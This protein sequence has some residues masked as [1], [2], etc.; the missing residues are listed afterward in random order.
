MAQKA[1]KRYRYR[2]NT[3]DLDW[4]E[5][6]ADASQNIGEVQR[7]ISAIAGAGLLIE[8]LRR[9]S[10]AG[11]VMAV[12]GL[13][14]LY[15]AATGY[16]LALGAMGIDMRP[17]QD[18]NRLGRRKVHSER[19]TKISR[20][21]EI[22]RPPDELYRFWRTLDNL[23]KIMS[24][25]ASVY[26]IT[27]RLS[28]WVVKTMTGLPTI[29]WDAEIINDVQNERIGWRSL[30]DADVDHAGSVEF[31]PIDKGQKTRVTVTLQYAPIAG[32]LGTAVA[33]FIGEDPEHKIADD[34]QRFKESMEAGNVLSSR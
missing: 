22:N 19:A 25:L 18:T 9:R 6:R 10:V 31:E 14:L 7:L 1:G 2:T 24:H 32:R 15:R 33:K 13:S 16:C 4:R 5:E 29:E 12:G 23:P 11:G 28:H 17:H 8:A 21:V 3:Q 26:V 30:N 34:L 27:D 20:S